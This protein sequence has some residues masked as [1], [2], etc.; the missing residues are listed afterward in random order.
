[1]FGGTRINNQPVVFL[2][3]DD[4]AVRKAISLLMMSAG[5]VCKSYAS[6]KEFLAVYDSSCPGCVV[7]DRRMPGMS[8]LD[9]QE[10]LAAMDLAPQIIIITGHGDVPAA[11]RAMKQGALDF[12]E[13]PFGDQALLDAVQRA[14]DKDLSHRDSI[15]SRQI[16]LDLLAE[17]TPREKEVCDLVIEGL[18]NK[19]VADQLN[20]SVKTVEFHRSNVMKKL[21]V[22]S[23]A[24]LVQMVLKSR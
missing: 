7:T 2:I 3:E 5:L 16:V 4:D 20:L 6:G 12:I 13:K 11:V 10:R 22:D 1:M 18:P 17:L 19:L 21:E 14:I 15:R 23:V 8:G 24:A 9:L